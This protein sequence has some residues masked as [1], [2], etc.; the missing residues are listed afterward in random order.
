MN[1]KENEELRHCARE[2]IAALVSVE[3]KGEREDLAKCLKGIIEEYY[4][5]VDSH[6]PRPLGEWLNNTGDN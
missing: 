4:K 6:I 2:I 1:S 3:D 5:E